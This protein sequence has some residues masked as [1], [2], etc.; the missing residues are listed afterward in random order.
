MDDVFT[1]ESSSWM[2][3]VLFLVSISRFTYLRSMKAAW[4]FSATVWLKELALGVVFFQKKVLS[5]D[6][7]NQLVCFEHYPMEHWEHPI[8]YYRFSVGFMFPLAILLVRR[9]YYPTL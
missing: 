3:F 9:S 2:T 8:N 7:T 1:L 5:R 4:L 6:K